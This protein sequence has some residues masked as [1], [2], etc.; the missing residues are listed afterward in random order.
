MQGVVSGN[1]FPGVSSWD[2]VITGEVWIGPH[3]LG[4]WVCGESR[5]TYG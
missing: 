4:W 5:K 2:Y 1:G 3:C